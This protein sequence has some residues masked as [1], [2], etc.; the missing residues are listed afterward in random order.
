M[1]SPEPLPPPPAAV[2]DMVTTEGS[3]LLATGETGQAAAD[4]AAVAPE[5]DDAVDEL[6]DAIAAP[7][8]PP[9]TPTT[10]K[11]PASSHRPVA[12]CMSACGVPVVRPGGASRGVPFAGGG[13]VSGRLT[14]DSLICLTGGRLRG[15]RLVGTLL[16]HADPGGGPAAQRPPEDQAA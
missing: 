6:G 7:I 10:A 13:L 9:M 4:P 12:A 2:A 15:G 1:T 11:A 5:A 8:S 16:G 14:G 3:T